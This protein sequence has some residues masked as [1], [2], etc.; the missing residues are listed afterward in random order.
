MEVNA[1]ALLSPVSTKPSVLGSPVQ[2][3]KDIIQHRFLT[4]ALV[5]RTLRNRY[6]MA[7]LGYIWL[8]LEPLLLAATYWF[9]FVMLAGNPDEMY[10]V[11]VLVGVIV[12]GTF[13]KSLTGSVT[14][15]SNNSQMIHMAYFPRII[16]PFSI[17]SG[18]IITSLG[19]SLVLLPIVLILKTPIT[20][21][22]LW[23]PF[24]IIIAGLMGGMFGMM[25]APLNCGQRDIEHLFRFIVRAGFFFSP[26]MWTA[27]MALQRGTWGE[28]A[29]WNPMV[30]PITMVRHALEGKV[31]DLP[32]ASVLMSITFFSAC[33]FFGSILFSQTEKEAVKYL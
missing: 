4:I 11:W 33:A 3:I 27:E 12:W 31:I 26:V 28:Y 10:P 30:M 23:I 18:I 20:A 16:F 1:P 24:G 22:L 8:V 29:L 25:F 6:R 17:T 9:L 14:S 5:Q 32:L 15:L 19:S 13:G 21:H 7:G 2:A